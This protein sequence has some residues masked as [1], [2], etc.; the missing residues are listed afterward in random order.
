MYFKV[1][2]PGSWVGQKVDKSLAF[3]S[4]NIPT[5]I[6]GHHADGFTQLNDLDQLLNP[7][8]YLWL[9]IRPGGQ[10]WMILALHL[11]SG[12]IRHRK[13]TFPLTN[14]DQPQNRQYKLTKCS[15]IKIFYSCIKTQAQYW[16]HNDLNVLQDIQ[17]G[18]NAMSSCILYQTVL[19]QDQKIVQYWLFVLEVDNLGRDISL[20]LHHK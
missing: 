17:A 9:L 3:S 12:V 2:A 4:I 15:N 14:S 13:Q 19:H 10:T 16:K 18:C 5:P 8:V 20:L 6:Y 11:I 1:Q 7:E